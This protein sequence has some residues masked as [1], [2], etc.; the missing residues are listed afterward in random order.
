MWH[1]RL[2][3]AVGE[4]HVVELDLAADP[5]ELD[6]VGRVAQLGLLVE[7]LEDLVQRRHPRLVGRVELRQR[8]DR[9]EEVVQRG[10]ERHQHADR[11]LAV[12]RLDAAVEQDPGG[13]EPAQQLDGRE[14][15]RVEVDGLHVRLAVLVVEL[16]EAVEVALLLGER[17]HDADARQRLL[18]VGGDRRDLLARGAVGVGGDDPERERA[19]RQHRED[20]EGQQRQL[21][22]EHDQDHRRADQRQRRAEQRHHAVGDELVERLHVVG[23]PR[24]QHAGLLARVEADRQRLQV[25]EELDPQVLQHPLADPAREVGL[26]VGRAPVDQRGDQEGDHDPGQRLQVARHDAVVDRQLG[27]RRRRERGGRGDQQRAEHQ[28]RAR[29]GR[30]AAARAARAACARGRRSG[31]AAAAAR[32]GGDGAVHRPATRSIGSRLRNTW[33]GRPL[34]GDLRVQRRARQ[35]L[36][37]R[38]VRDH[39]AVLE[40]DDLV[41]ERDRREPVGDHERRAARHHLAQ[42]L[43]DRLLGRRVDGG[44]GVVED[45]D[46]R[47]GEQRARDR[48][49]LALAARERQPALADARVVALAAARR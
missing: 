24:D 42:R 3:L 35:Q 41:G 15:G 5:A 10:D 4:D 28:Q 8:L 48:E 16:G 22:V 36:V 25:R 2:A 7:Q 37:V 31:A 46:P 6:R 40:H 30:G 12:D 13:R 32:P 38:A 14:V 26:R 18:Q 34:C 44:G 45:Q 47:V 19:D 11:D 1:R 21:E 39:L 9:V 17:A 20:E 43:L 27:Q 23:Q 29:R 49:P 33:S